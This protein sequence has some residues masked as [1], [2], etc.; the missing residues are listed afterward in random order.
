[1]G[2]SMNDADRFWLCMDQ[3]TNL[4]NIVG[5]MEFDAPIEFERLRATIE[6]RLLGALD[7][8]RR[9]VIRPVS[10]LGA[11]VWSKDQAFDMRAH[12]HRLALPSPRTM[13]APVGHRFMASIACCSLSLAS[14]S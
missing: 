2:K 1:M 6:I 10:G 7:R 8:F 4:M 12:L 11:Y 3:P 14:S 5:L 9:R 13:M